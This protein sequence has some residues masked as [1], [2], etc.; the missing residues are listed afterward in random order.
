[1][2]TVGIYARVSTADQEISEQIAS[3][4]KFAKKKK[5]KVF[6]T[7]IDE[8]ISGYTIDRPAFEKCLDDLTDGKFD[9]LLV[10]AEDRLHRSNSAIER[11]FVQDAIVKNNVTLWTLAQ[12]KIDL[13]SFGGELSHQFK[14]IMAK[15]EAKEINRRML[16]GRRAKMKAGIP[17]HAKKLYGRKII[18]Q[19]DGTYTFE[20][21]Q[22]EVDQIRQ[23][24]DLMISKRYGWKKAGNAVGMNWQTLRYNTMEVP[25]DHFIQKNVAKK[26]LQ[27]H[28][29]YKFPI[30]EEYRLFDDET[31]EKLKTVVQLNTTI[32]GPVAKD[33]LLFSGILRHKGIALQRYYKKKGDL[34][35]YRFH[36]KVLKPP[37]RPFYINTDTIDK[38]L[39]EAIAE[40]LSNP[41]RFKEAVNGKKKS[42]D[43]RKILEKEIKQLEKVLSNNELKI[44]RVID[45]IAEGTIKKADV[46]KKMAKL[47]SVKT[48][49]TE[50]LKLKT[51]E[52]ETLP[53]EDDI[54]RVQKT[55]HDDIEKSYF[56][57]SGKKIKVPKPDMPDEY[58]RKAR[59]D[60]ILDLSFDKKR[61]LLLKIFSGK[62]DQDRKFGIYVDKDSDTGEIKYHCYGRL[63]SFIFNAGIISEG[64]AQK[65]LFRESLDDIIKIK[66]T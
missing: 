39:F 22:V 55:V 41:K 11:A 47:R 18:V 49:V 34:R 32:R 24:V 40:H 50:S 23:A 16:K 7:Y 25:Q 26:R 53:S 2:K 27:V 17:M 6:E 61:E 31:I 20:V 37:V 29:V 58:I 3:L 46:E 43:K 28:E 12:G 57:K 63:D 35:Y 10:E 33:P 13:T 19:D 65:K 36:G 8:G 44:D 42:V 45:A 4:N 1:M 51:E 14:M 59:K 54:K 9:T 64:K 56:S 21:N 5:W 62:D 66:T 60:H 52:L 48:N 15:E 38:P 30:P